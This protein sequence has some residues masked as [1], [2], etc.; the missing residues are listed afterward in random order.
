ML[1]NIISRSHE[2]VVPGQ[3]IYDHVLLAYELIRG[4]SRKDE[5]PRCMLQ[6]DIQKADDIVDWQAL[7][8]I[9]K[10]LGFP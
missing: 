9:L 6:M 8:S 4:Y 10:E 3:R 2:A 7:R 1:S 5:V